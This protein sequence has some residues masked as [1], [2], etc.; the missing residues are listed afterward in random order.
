MQQIAV[1]NWSLLTLTYESQHHLEAWPSVFCFHMMQMSLPKNTCLISVHVSFGR[2]VTSEDRIHPNKVF[3]VYFIY[4]TIIHTYISYIQYV[5]LDLRLGVKF[6]SPGLFLVVYFRGSNFTR[7]KCSRKHLQLQTPSH[8]GPLRCTKRWM[9]M[10]SDVPTP[11][12]NLV[13]MFF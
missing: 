3:R 13:H 8:C 2:P 12:H 4:Y 1:V 11:G 5:Y 10:S 9:S 6:S 7:L